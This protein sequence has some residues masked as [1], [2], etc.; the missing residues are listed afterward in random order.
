M[1]A[2]LEHMEAQPVALEEH[3]GMYCPHRLT[4]DPGFL[5]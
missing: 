1:E 4:L 2:N 3:D 5:L